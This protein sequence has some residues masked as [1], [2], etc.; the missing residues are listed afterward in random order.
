MMIHDKIKNSKI[1]IAGYNMECRE[2]YFAFRNILHIVGY[3]KLNNLRNME[4]R[5]GILF[6]NTQDKLEL[7]EY[8]LEAIPADE[9]YIVLCNGTTS[10]NWSNEDK[11]FDELLFLKGFE[12]EN[13]YIDAAIVYKL[14][15]G[16]EWKQDFSSGEIL[17]F[18]CGKYGQAFYKRFAK[19]YN[20]C[21]FL[22]NKEN[23]NE[24]LGLPVFRVNKE[25]LQ[26][27]RVVICS[28]VYRLEM[29]QQLEDMGMRCYV[30]YV[31]NHM[32]LGK[33]MA[34][35]GTC[36]VNH[37]AIFLN[38]REAFTVEYAKFD[39]LYPVEERSLLGFEIEKA[40]KI[41]A[42]CDAVFCLTPVPGTGAYF[43]VYNY[44][45]RHDYQCKVIR[46][47]NYVFQGL[48]PQVTLVEHNRANKY[49]SRL[50]IF[51]S[52]QYNWLFGD[53]NINNYL[54]DGMSNQQVIETIRDDNYYSKEAC[55]D[56]L[57]QSLKMIQLF[58]KFSDIKLYDFMVEN[59]KKH[60][61]FRDVSHFSAYT[62]LEVSRQVLALLG[63]EDDLEPE[64]KDELSETV[65]CGTEIPI[66]PSVYKALDLNFETKQN[67]WRIVRSDFSEKEVCFEEWVE[68]YIR[69]VRS[70]M[71]AKEHDSV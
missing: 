67:N 55:I 30:N 3:A 38:Y 50:N 33:I 62:L 21:G 32:L 46:I 20:I 10:V 1:I 47:S 43:D 69:Y 45:K 56:N 49:C 27:K 28:V 2:F 39:F 66:Y 31:T 61:L 7:K 8:R 41:L 60:L 64:R 70:C 9:C 51:E 23:E 44:L 71:E 16:D 26:G 19:D 25:N 59:Y 58:D 52:F 11:Q 24:C 6:D 63:I 15:Q 42:Y 57:Q 29:M 18:G 22:S 35:I 34:S 14:F 48:H 53:Q 12:Y 5:H 17:I 68:Y 13:N 4:C 36:H 54:E 65:V 37:S 40:K